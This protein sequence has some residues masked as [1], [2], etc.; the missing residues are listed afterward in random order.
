MNE[1]LEK[2]FYFLRNFEIKDFVNS[3]IEKIVVCEDLKTK[4]V[5]FVLLKVKNWN[6][7]K[8][9]LDA[10]AG[11]WIDTEKSDYNDLDD[12]EDDENFVFKD[13]TKE[14][15]VEESVISK[16]YC[17]PND[18]NCQIIIELENCKKI[19][20]RSINSKIFDSE[21]EIVKN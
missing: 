7:Q 8:Y 4:N 15:K 11:F 18:E 20:L 17:E 19:I 1:E 2:E 10:G 3:K 12:I 9:F 21:I 14:L 13:Y 5:V 6:W 16:I